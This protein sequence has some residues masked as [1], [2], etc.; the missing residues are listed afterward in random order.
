MCKFGRNQT[1]P[2]IKVFNKNTMCVNSEEYISPTFHHI[3]LSAV[4]WGRS[5]NL[6]APSSFL[7]FAICLT[8]RS[9]WFLYPTFNPSAWSW[10]FPWFYTYNSSFV[11]NFSIMGENV[12][13]VHNKSSIHH[14][15]GSNARKCNL[16][17][18]RFLCI[19]AVLSKG[20]R[21]LWKLV[22]RGPSLSWQSVLSRSPT[23]QGSTQKVSVRSWRTW[24]S[25]AS[26]VWNRELLKNRNIG[27]VMTM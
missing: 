23:I 3:L 18:V 19:V 21:C 8:F 22:A 25:R 13:K 6:M 16:E 24:R 4:F 20:T 2:V 9:I 10:E 11:F 17:F 1:N 5:R 27:F 14:I 15:M 12:H 26:G 7:F